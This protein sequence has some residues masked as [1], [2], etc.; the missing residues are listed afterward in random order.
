[1]LAPRTCGKGRRHWA[2]LQR[3][4]A[5]D[6]Q[7]RRLQAAAIW[8]LGYWVQ[9]FRIF[10]PKHSRIQRQALCERRDFHPKVRRCPKTGLLLRNLN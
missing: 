3:F 9:G 10:G 6:Q 5:P 2:L 7:V 8:G 1:M 4:T